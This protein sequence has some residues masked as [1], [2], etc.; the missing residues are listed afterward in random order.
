MD[1]LSPALRRERF[2]EY[3]TPMSHLADASPHRRKK[4]RRGSQGVASTADDVGEGPNEAISSDGKSAKTKA[5]FRSFANP[6]KLAAPSMLSTKL[7]VSYPSQSSP[8][9]LSTYSNSEISSEPFHQPIT[10]I[11]GYHDSAAAVRNEVYSRPENV[12]VR[13]NYRSSGRDHAVESMAFSSS[14][15]QNLSGSNFST[16]LPQDHANWHHTHGS[17]ESML[18]PSGSS[19]RYHR[20]QSQRTRSESESVL[21]Y[22]SS[23]PSLRTTFN[24]NTSAQTEVP[25]TNLSSDID[26]VG[27]QT[28]HSSTSAVR[29]DTSNGAIYW[30]SHIHE[31]AHTTATTYQHNPALHRSHSFGSRDYAASSV[32]PIHAPSERDD[33]YN[34]NLQGRQSGTRAVPSTQYPGTSRQSR[35]VFGKPAVHEEP[36]PAMARNDL[37]DS[38]VGTEQEEESKSKISVN[39]SQPATHASKVY[40][41]NQESSRGDANCKPPTTFKKIALPFFRWFGATANTPGIRRIKVGVYHDP[42]MDVPDPTGEHDDDIASEAKVDF[43]SPSEH[44]EE[45]LAVQSTE[46]KALEASANT[47]LDGTPSVAHAHHISGDS[48]ISTTAREL[49][50]VDRPRYPRRDILLQLTTLFL[51]YFKA[52]CFP[53]LDEAEFMSGART[54]ELPAIVANAVCAMTA[55]FSTHQDLHRAKNASDS[56]ADMAKVLVVPML[57]WPSI[58]VI[59]A[60]VIL[61][62]AEFGAGADAGLWMYIGMAMR[63]ATDLGLQHELTINSMATKKQQDRARY[64]FWAIVSLDRITCFGTGRPV[65]VRDDTYDCA[66][67]PLEDDPSADTFVFGHIVRTLLHRGRIGELLNRREDGLPLEERGARLRLLWLDLAEYY[68]NLPPSLIFGVNTFRRL[69]AADKGCAFVYLH[70]LLQS[71]ISLI[72]RPSLLRRFDKEMSTAV[73][74]KLAAIANH[75][76][77]TII[78]ILRFA[79]DAGQHRPRTNDEDPEVNPYIDC[80]PYLDQLILP[81]GRALLAE[82]ETVNDALR[83]LG[84]MPQSSREGS[85]EE[86]SSTFKPPV[87]SAHASSES[88]NAL[89]TRRQ[90]ANTNIATC[91]EVLDRVALWWNGAAWP[92]RA[93]RQEL[94]GTG[95]VGPDGT[96]EDA[97]PAPI[98]DVEMVLKWAKARRHRA[99]KAT[100]QASRRQSRTQQRMVRS[101]GASEREENASQ[102]QEE[103][104][105]W[106]AEGASSLGSG[107]SP[108]GLGFSG[109]FGADAELDVD[110]L[111]NAW[112]S[113]LNS[114]ESTNAVPA[115]TFMSK[116]GPSIELTHPNRT[117]MYTQDIPSLTFSSVTS[118][119][120]HSQ[121]QRTRN[122]QQHVLSP[123]YLSRTNESIQ[124]PISESLANW[125]AAN[126]P[127]MDINLSTMQLEECFFEPQNIPHS[128]HSH[129]SL[130]GPLVSHDDNVLVPSSFTGDEH[131]AAG[132][133]AATHTRDPPFEQNDVQM[134]MGENLGTI[135]HEDLDALPSALFNAFTFPAPASSLPSNNRAVPRPVRSEDIK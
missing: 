58:D 12:P 108:L 67:P 74:P 127:D 40:G 130:Q 115:E 9:A 6:T 119:T 19:D 56:F 36:S 23:I 30:P 18:Y 3:D 82:R 114:I 24:S 71:T 46:A 41:S 100:P 34:V 43:T 49:F 17:Q 38:N 89:N 61:S 86:Q 117:N 122:L 109:N 126:R 54:G 90:Y 81:A 21:P 102:G 37:A 62:Y 14:P 132:Q 15:L 106:S 103:N 20:A 104:N 57:S 13:H 50:E 27:S 91:Q 16:T 55:R 111:I 93:L 59:E 79:M 125:S 60:L 78:S 76:S 33:V 95:E 129:S 25:N 66:L 80:N 116:F 51:K 96:D 64:L 97:Q 128:M 5:V 69:A 63:M 105:D 35:R 75:A 1:D 120:P 45:T 94:Q 134:M 87:V 77:A 52:S 11:L 113:E 70:V 48:A 32:H 22:G 92:A 135:I 47:P 4:P 28:S 42:D 118:G 7:A 131:K 101:S 10:P 2:S 26:N 85:Q 44:G 8:R 68:E 123:S 112:A 110:I 73:P 39:A 53:W 107:A 84:L 88:I 72:N 124:P 98:R 121:E 65:T 83:G 133:V 31:R 29:S 99:N